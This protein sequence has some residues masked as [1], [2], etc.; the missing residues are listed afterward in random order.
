MDFPMEN[1]GELPGGAPDFPPP[2]KAI[3][4]MAFDRPAGE[5][6]RWLGEPPVFSRYDEELEA[7]VIVCGAGIAG[8]SA[9]R[10]A[11]EAGASVLVFEKAAAPQGRSGQFAV[12]GGKL[13]ERWGLNGLE[14]A[15]RILALLVRE[16][17]YKVDQR[18]LRHV[19]RHIGE[20]FDWYLEGL[21]EDGVFIADNCTDVPPKGTRTHVMLMQH[22]AQPRYHPEE[23]LSPCYHVTVQIRPTHLGV[24]KNNLRLAEKTGNLTCRFKTPARKL[25]R[26]PDSGRI[27]GVVAQ[28]YDGKVICARARRGVVLATGDFSGDRDMLEALCPSVADNHAIPLG[29]A[30]DRRPI[31]TGDGHRMAMWAG[32]RLE[33]GPYA[34]MAHNMGAVIGVTPFLELDRNGERFMNED[35]NGQQFENRLSMT[36]G[37]VA[38]QIFDSAWP[39]QI[40]YMPYGHSSASRVLDEEAVARGECFDDLTPMDGFASQSF[41]DRTVRGDTP[42]R[43]EAFRADT[44]EELIAKTGMPADTALASIERYN[45]LAR[46]HKDEDFGKSAARMFPIE[47]GPFY[48]ARM[49]PAILLCCLG[50]LENDDKCRVLDTERRILPGLYVAGNVQGNRCAVDYPT[51]LPGWSHSMA[52]SLG[53]EAGRNAAAGL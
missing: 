3:G 43:V 5:K 46:R 49:T 44:L 47:K 9:A 45:D 26:D 8:V 2:D 48:A 15:D 10:A 32:A 34:P 16:S 39:E 41:L 19:L 4:G 33:D 36:P 1:D 11:C 23:E 18:L 25:L 17:H 24:L 28:D 29:V 27:C 21:P 50:G 13:M 12:L 42:F 20:D 31:N 35:C 22:P 30:P 7:D 51:I 37:K 53:R 40:E 14:N 52:L 38:W 6:P